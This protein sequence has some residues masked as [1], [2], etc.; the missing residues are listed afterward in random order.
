MHTH[1]QRPRALIYPARVVFTPLELWMERRRGRRWCAL[2]AAVAAA[3]AA[4]DGTTTTAKQSARLIARNNRRL[5][6]CVCVRQIGSASRHPRGIAHTYEKKNS[7][8]QMHVV[9]CVPY[10]LAYVVWCGLCATITV[11]K[12]RRDVCVY[13]G[14]ITLREGRHLYI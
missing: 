1:R 10:K 2:T 11:V 3:L 14:G 12:Y 4:D 13:D 8:A 5:C 7:P 9:L 6:V